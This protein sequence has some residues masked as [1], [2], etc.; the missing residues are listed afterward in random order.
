MKLIV[1]GATGF[2]GSEVLRQCI[3]NPGVTSVLVVS[4]R[5]PAKELMAS[6]KV[7]VILHEDF[8]EW[9]TSLLEQLEGAEGCIWYL[10][11]NWKPFSVTDA[12]TKGLLEEKLQISPTLRQPGRSPLTIR[13]QLPRLLQQIWLRVLPKLGGNFPLFFAVGTEPSRRKTPAYGYMLTV[14]NSRYVGA[15]LGDSFSIMLNI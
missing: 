4:R 8:S 9:P 2:I 14:G 15:M 11:G 7:K 1:T 6:P 12:V 10:N 3:A 5:E 13:W